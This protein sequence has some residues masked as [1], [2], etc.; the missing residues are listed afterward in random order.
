MKKLLLFL[1]LGVFAATG[2]YWISYNPQIESTHTVPK[3]VTIPDNTQALF[4]YS[5][6]QF[7][8][9]IRHGDTQ[10][11]T[12]LNQSLNLLASKLEGYKKQGYDI[13]EL[14][15]NF[16]QFLQDIDNVS[17]K[18]SLKLQQ[19]HLYNQTEHAQEE[20]FLT[21][22]EQIGLY[23]LKK[24]YNNLDNLRK[25]FIKEPTKEKKTAY[26]LEYKNL[27]NSITELYLDTKIELPL[28]NYIVNHKNYFDT[29]VT[30]YDSVG[31]EQINRIRSNGYEIKAQ[32]Q[33]LPVS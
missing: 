26:N 22:I 14:E 10:S 5:E 16:S 1:P 13:H 9:I 31:Y 2:I 29:I 28:L 3:T 8:D 30:V 7:N 18:F 24:S 23:E 20:K 6:H 19:L 15:E 4:S 17:S 33:V 11:I 12:Q 25:D 32:L 21:S 27:Q